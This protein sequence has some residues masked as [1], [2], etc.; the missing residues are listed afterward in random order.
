MTDLSSSHVIED[1][2]ARCNENDQLGFCYFYFDGTDQILSEPSVMYRSL[3]SQLAAQKTTLPRSLQDFYYIYGPRG[4]FRDQVITKAT[5]AKKAKECMRMFDTVYVVLDGLDEC[6]GSINPEDI[7]QF[8]NAVSRRP[9]KVHSIVFSRNLE[10]LRRVFESFDVTSIS[11]ETETLTFDLKISLR[12]SFSM[13]PKLS[14]WPSSLKQTVENSL[15]ARANGSFRWFD[16]QLQAITRC[17]TPAAV[18]KVLSELPESL[19]AHYARILEGIEGNNWSSVKSLLRW[20]TFSLRPVSM[21]H[22]REVDGN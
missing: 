1:L 18:K 13:N 16:C 17:K 14:R 22:Q 3:V 10:Q 9:T 19:E 6:E 20:V 5:W 8:I 2:Q 7:V 15:L 4:R 11:I 21:A 12:S